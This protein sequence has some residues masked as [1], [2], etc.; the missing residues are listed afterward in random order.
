MSLLGSLVKLAQDFS[1]FI[2]DQTNC[3]LVVVRC[4]CGTVWK[5][6]SPEV[7]VAGPTPECPAC[8]GSGKKLANDLTCGVPVL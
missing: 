2:E 6:L 3:T 8:L 4:P 5:Y 7:R 1:G